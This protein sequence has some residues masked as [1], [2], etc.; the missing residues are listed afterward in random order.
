MTETER[1]YIEQDLMSLFPTDKLIYNDLR[2]YSNFTIAKHTNFTIAFDK[3]IYYSIVEYK[4]IQQSNK[5]TN[6]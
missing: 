2:H 3:D 4:L 5:E 6:D 1:K